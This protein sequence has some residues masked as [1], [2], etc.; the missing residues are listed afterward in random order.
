MLFK[1]CTNISFLFGVVIPLLLS[2]NA[3][4]A[5]CPRTN[6]VV[7]QY[8]RSTATVLFSCCCEDEQ[9]IDDESL[10][11]FLEIA[12]EEYE[13]P[14][15]SDIKCIE[16]RQLEHKVQAFAVGQRCRHGFP[17]AFGFHPILGKKV[18]SGLFRLSC[19]LLVQAID[20]WENEGAVREMSD[21][22]RASD[23][24]SSNYVEANRRTA[25]IRRDLIERHEEGLDT[26]YAKLGSFNTERYLSS[27]IAGI[28][29]EHTWDIKCLHAHVADHLCRPNNDSKDRNVI[30]EEALRKLAEEKGIDIL[31]TDYCCQQCD[32]GR[33]R[34][35]TDWSYVPKKNRQ[36][37]RSTRKR[38]KELRDKEQS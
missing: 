12:G 30:G 24:M 11:T 13:K 6:L 38:R 35:P 36:G 3:S 23:A 10:T 2:I 32:I 26:V 9:K 21:M 29:E 4:T 17:Q 19:P 25:A 8:G 14:S 37:L 7:Q 31:G 22:V 20:K 5:L 16:E 18:T 27:G 1:N 15:S 34:K 33:E 28:P